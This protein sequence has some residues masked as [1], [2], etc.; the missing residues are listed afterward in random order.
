M[1]FAIRPQDGHLPPATEQGEEVRLART[2]DAEEGR[3]GTAHE[4]LDLGIGCYD[5]FDV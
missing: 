4:P 5:G 2:R 3:T 1:Y